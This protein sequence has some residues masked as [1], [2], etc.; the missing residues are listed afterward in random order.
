[1]I[2]NRVVS[3]TGI[4]KN[5]IS[6]RDP[7]FTSELWKNL[8]QLF[9]T[10]LSFYKAYKPQADGLAE[11]MIQ[12]LEDMLGRICANG[13]E[14]KDCDGFT[15]DWYTFLSSLKLAYKRAINAST[16][17]TP[18]ILEKGW[19]PRLPQDSLRKSL[20]GIHRPDSS[21]KGI[22]EKARKHSARCME[23]SFSYSKDKW[24]KNNILLQTPKW[25]IY[26]FYLPLTSITSR[27]VR[28]PKNPLH[29]LSLSRSSMGK[30]LLK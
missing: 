15:H 4:F 24:D 1:M 22:L 2:W 18:A 17:Q 16:N 23:D 7:K 20:V 8:H 29:E 12:N 25:N 28:S 13:L 21:F 5:I 27:D 6:N 11:R 26:Y 14:F 3:W 19:N 9:G 30:I 10:K